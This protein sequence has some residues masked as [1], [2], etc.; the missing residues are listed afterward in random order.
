MENLH[1]NIAAVERDT[2]LSKDVL[3]VWERRYGFPAPLRDANG[4]RCYP[5][6]QVERLRMIKRLI[7]Q[8]HRPGKLIDASV[9]ELTIRATRQAQPAALSSSPPLTEELAALIAMIKHHDASGYQQAMQQQLARKGLQPFVQDIVAPLSDLVGEEWERG[10][11]QVFEE[12]LFTELT[13]RLL[14]QAI[15]NFSSGGQLA[16]LRPCILLTSVPGEQHAL[17]LLM[18]ETLFTLEGAKCIPL[19]TGTPLLDI[20]QAATAHRADI[21]GLSFS[22]A[23]PQQQIPDVLK[24]LR[25]LLPEKVGLWVGGGG[26]QKLSTIEG[27]QLLPSLENLKPALADWGGAARS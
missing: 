23:F 13:T 11:L 26:V 18:A 12:H 16:P 19:G 9:E 8:G 7:D 17:G 1:F 5:L 4:E 2:G 27:V 20:A 3:R 10:V 22:S 25:K 21:V 15:A 24:Q 14:R 6:E